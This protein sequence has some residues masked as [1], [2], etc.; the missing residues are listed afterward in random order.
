[1][2][3]F[4]RTI[5][6]PSYKSELPAGRNIKKAEGVSGPFSFHYPSSLTVI[7]GGFFQTEN[8]I[9]LV[10]LHVPRDTHFL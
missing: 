2:G 3:I 1:M 6:L 8:V 9:S 10:S 4:D 7:S 5:F